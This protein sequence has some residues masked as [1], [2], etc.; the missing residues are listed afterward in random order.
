[1]VTLTKTKVSI[2]DVGAGDESVA[3][4]LYPDAEVFTLDIDKGLGVDF[5]HD[6]RKPLP[7]D[8]CDKF[9]LV[10][11][12]HVL[13][14][15]A[16]AEVEPVLRNLQKALIPGKGELMVIVPSLEWAAKEIAKDIPSP[17]LLSHLYGNQSNDH[18]FHKS[19]FTL[20]LLRAMMEK[21]GYVTRRAYQEPF[22]ITVDNG[23]EVLGFKSFQNIVVGLRSE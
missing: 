12:S 5:V 19:G 1:M 8:L 11:M 2:L 6:L 14:H 22:L 9:D 17:V 20:Y 7:K 15:M 21:V 18:Q 10:V 13:E 3:K 4:T 16:L 23:E